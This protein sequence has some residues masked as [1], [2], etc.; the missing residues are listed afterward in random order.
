LCP[1]Y[2]LSVIYVVALL[3]VFLFGMERYGYLAASL[4]GLV[5]YSCKLVS[6]NVEYFT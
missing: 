5:K 4:K 2:H 1:F 3:T 6:L